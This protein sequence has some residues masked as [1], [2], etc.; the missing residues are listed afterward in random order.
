MIISQQHQIPLT[1]A[2]TKSAPGRGAIAEALYREAL[3]LFNNK[4]TQTGTVAKSRSVVPLNE[5]ESLVSAIVTDNTTGLFVQLTGVQA[6][7]GETKSGPYLT[8]GKKYLEES[9]NAQLSN[10][11]VKLWA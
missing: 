4:P 8:F 2:I 6:V 7:N 9:K 11:A 3:N 5:G 10:T 1:T